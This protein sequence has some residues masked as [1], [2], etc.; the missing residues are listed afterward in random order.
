MFTATKGAKKSR[1]RRRIAHARRDPRHRRLM[2]EAL[3]DRTLLSVAAPAPLNVALISD[4]VA[5]AQQ[6]R[7]AA[8]N[9]TIA[10]V[11]HSDTMT[12]MGLDNLLA[13]VSA[14]HNGA[15]HWAPGDCGPR[16]PW[17]S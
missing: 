9:G 10:I 2:C 8:A 6:V 17:R 16:Q 14:A 5:Q 7:D 4:A 11:Y 15:P 3:E 12:T 13:S 1:N